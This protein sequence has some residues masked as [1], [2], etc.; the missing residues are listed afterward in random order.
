MGVVIRE[1]THP[2]S[3]THKTYNKNGWSFLWVSEREREREREREIFFFF[4][5]LKV[6][7][8]NF[9]NIF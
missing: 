9:L 3:L 1:L 5:F 6:F 2:Y 4:E 8:Q 7:F